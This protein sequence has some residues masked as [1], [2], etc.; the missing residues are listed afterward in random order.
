MT[1][2]NRREFLQRLSALAATLAGGAP[3]L[4]SAMMPRDLGNLG[5]AQAVGAMRRGD[6]TAEQYAQFCLMRAEALRDLNAFIT[7]EP[8][9]VLEAARKAD[10]LRASGA[11]LGPLHG[12]P[13]AIKDNIDTA[14]IPTTAATPTLRDNRPHA[15]APIL[16]SLYGAGAILLGKTNMH[17]LAF[18]Y[19]TNNTAFG[20][21]RNPYD[22]G[23][24]PGGSSGGTAVAI[25][26]RMTPVG[27]GTDTVGSVRVPA[28][29]CGIAGLRPSSGRYPGA[30][31]VPLSHS[32]DTAGPMAR[33]IA[34]L[35]LL[36]SV[37][38][39]DAAPVEPVPLA[40]LRLGV[41]RAYY[42]AQLDDEVERV[43][44]AALAKLAAAGARLVDIDLAPL[45]ADAFKAR[46][47]RSIQLFEL[48]PDLSRYLEAHPGAD[49][50]RVAA[51]LASPPVKT[52]IEDLVLGPDAPS[53]EVYDAVMGEY[54]PSLQAAFKQAFGTGVDAI[55]FPMT[56]VPALPIGQDAEFEVRGDKFPLVYLGRNADP[57]SC[58]GLPGI[59]LPA[60]LTKANLPVGLGLDAP[61]GGD[62]TLLGIGLSVER[63]LGRLPAPAM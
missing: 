61:A 25:A 3:R 35:I 58:A 32:R 45:P 42:W 15:D 6:L 17:E 2:S 21:A 1:R 23:R 55:V 36:D 43:A 62:R 14:G 57:G 16:A 53:R 56:Q 26:A 37:I 50:E 18:G 34:D 4:A 40:R 30:G 24:I 19:T 48:K 12:L 9:R 20:A 27:L 28:A 39:G 46:R 51:G 7:L 22:S 60:G 13:L 29:L 5:A 52:L 47:C 59:C 38:T 44:K 33:S 63:V 41:A 31:I 8:E 49:F 54:R 11:P 10:R